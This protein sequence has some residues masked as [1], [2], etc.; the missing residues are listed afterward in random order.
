[1][2]KIGLIISL[3]L[4][5]TSLHSITFAEDE[6]IPRIYTDN[7]ISESSFTSPTNQGPS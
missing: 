2:R 1:M 5:M 6:D 3:V 7:L 4:I